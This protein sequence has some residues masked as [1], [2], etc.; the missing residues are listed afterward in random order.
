MGHKI[1]S[2]S[3]ES[4]KQSVRQV[5][6]NYKQCGYTLKEI[7]FDRESAMVALEYDILELG[8]KLTLKASGQHVGL[9]EYTIGYLRGLCRATKNGVWDTYGYK[10]PPQWN[11]YLWRD[12]INVAN[13]VV[14]PGFDKS[15]AELFTGIPLDPLRDLR[16]QW[17]EIVIVKKAKRISADLEST[18]RW[19]VV[20]YRAP[21]GTG[22]ITFYMIDTGTIVNALKFTRAKWPR[23]VLEKLNNIVPSEV[24]RVEDN[25]GDYISPNYN[26]LS[27]TRDNIEDFS[28]GEDDADDDLLPSDLLEAY[29]EQEEVEER[30][31]DDTSSEIIDARNK[32]VE[33]YKNSSFNEALSMPSVSTEPVEDESV[34]PVNNTESDNTTGPVVE[35]VPP[36]LRRSARLNKVSELKSTAPQGYTTRS[37]RVSKPPDRLTYSAFYTYE[38]IYVLFEQA[39]KSDKAEAARKALDKELDIIENK[40][41]FHGILESSLDKEQRARI[42][43]SMVNYIEKY[44]PSGEF[45]K[46]KVRLLIRGDQ[47]WDVG[48]TESPV[49]RVECIFLI[50]NIA[51]LEDLEVVKIDFTAAYLNSKMVDDVKHKWV[52][53]PRTVV[54]KL[55]ERDR[56]KWEPF[57]RHDGTILVEMDKVMYGYKEAAIQWF[58]NHEMMMIEGE[59]SNFKKDPCFFYKFPETT[60]RREMMLVGTTVDDNVCA[61]TRKTNMKQELLDLMARFFEKY[62]VEE[63]DVINVIGIILIARTSQLALLRSDLLRS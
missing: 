62:T 40:A 43:R 34:T 49:C 15:P 12:S 33:A 39:L 59:F 17:G 36:T 37:S 55:I 32:F 31:T 14:R 19:G 8:I 53:L 30:V 6:G 3:I 2:K 27:N 13:R 20:I 58:N 1:A 10:P 50:M 38:D 48:Q 52:L 41:V 56:A 57:L 29:E 51:V 26:N 11:E 21:Y 18:A 4:M 9:I 22:V 35:E 42:I 24:F 25:T 28:D 23:R 60:G 44:L 63:G 5:Q 47:Q 61:F 7:I 45:D 16:A 54:Q 46:S